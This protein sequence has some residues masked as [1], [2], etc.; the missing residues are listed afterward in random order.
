MT[1]KFADAVFYSLGS[2][3]ASQKAISTKA[4]SLDAMLVINTTKL[5]DSHDDVHINGLWTKN[6]KENPPKLLLQEHKMSFNFVISDNVKASVETFTWK[7]LGF[8]FDGSTEALV[9]NA[10]IEKERN[11]FMFGQ[12]A[13]G[14]VKEHSVG[15][16]YIKLFLAINSDMADLSEE[17]AIWDKYYPEIAN[18]DKAEEKGYFWAITEAKAV[19]GSAVVKGS[20][21]AT[22]TL[23]ITASK[24]E[25][26]DPISIS[27]KNRRIMI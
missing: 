12:Y 15:M 20:N 22:P 2:G 17:K 11:T 6:V 8:K 27:Q 13:K 23:E 19:E 10:Q 18:K 1:L 25:T 26:T 21:F 16:Q 3:S 24:E 14:Y 5:L 7:E 4:D 9:F